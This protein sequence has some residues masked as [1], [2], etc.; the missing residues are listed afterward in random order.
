[1]RNKLAHRGYLSETLDTKVMKAKRNAGKARQRVDNRDKCLTF[2]GQYHSRSEGFRQILCRHWH[3][4]K[5][6]YPTVIEFKQ[7]PMM[8]F[9]KGSTIGRRLV[10]TDMRPQPRHYTFLGPPRDGM[11]CCKGCAQCRFVLTGDTFCSPVTNR[12]YNIRGHHSCDT[13]YVVYML[14][15][16]CNLIYIGE[17][18]QKIR[19]RFSQYRATVNTGNSVLPVSKHCLEKGHSAEDLRFRVIQHVPQPRRG[20]GTEYCC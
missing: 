10:R 8:P 18:I 15:C 7:P 13:S 3:L 2:V 11:F 6:A 9:K 14:A 16:P 5:D 12:S 19:D 1:M 17:T 4:L 20:G